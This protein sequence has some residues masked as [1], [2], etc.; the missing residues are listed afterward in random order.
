[1]GLKSRRIDF[2]S[3][4]GQEIFL[5]SIASRPTMGPTEPPIRVQEGSGGYFPGVKRPGSEAN[6]L[7]PSSVKVKNEWSYTSTYPDVFIAWYV[8]N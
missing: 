3:R 7:P 6:H 8:I 1:M 4:Q 5:F 2:D